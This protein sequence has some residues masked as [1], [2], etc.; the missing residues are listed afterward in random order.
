MAWTGLY[1]GLADKGGMSLVQVGAGVDSGGLGEAAG[2]VEAM[3]AP[4]TSHKG[5]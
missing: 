4:G 2:A 1:H 5:R 3:T